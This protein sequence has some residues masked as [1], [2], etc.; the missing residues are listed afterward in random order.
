MDNSFKLAI[1][2]MDIV[3]EFAK[4]GSQVIHALLYPKEKHQKHYQQQHQK[5]DQAE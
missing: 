2:L 4:S 3:I 1:G 5:A